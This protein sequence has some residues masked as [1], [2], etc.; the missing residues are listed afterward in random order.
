MYR[1]QSGSKH[2]SLILP[3]CSSFAGV[4]ARCWGK[5]GEVRHCIHAHRKA[6]LVLNAI[7]F[8]AVNSIHNHRRSTLLFS[9][10]YK[11]SETVTSASCCLSS[12]NDCHLRTQTAGSIQKFMTAQVE[13]VWCTFSNPCLPCSAGR[14]RT[15]TSRSGPS[16]PSWP[17]QTSAAR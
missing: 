9:I 14:R 2:L 11:V 17:T 13:K 3:P 6:L 15:L 4:A 8:Q 12:V 7:T 16:H 10:Q 5:E 1:P